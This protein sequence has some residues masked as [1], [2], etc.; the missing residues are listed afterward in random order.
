[1]SGYPQM[2]AVRFGG[3]SEVRAIGALAPAIQFKLVILQRETQALGH[4]ILLLFDGFVFKLENFSAAKANQVIVV[5]AGILELVNGSA[6]KKPALHG[7]PRLYQAADGA[8]NGSQP[9]PGGLLFHDAEEFFGGKM[10]ARLHKFRNDHLTLARHLQLVFRKVSLIRLEESVEIVG[11]R[12]WLAFAFGAHGGGIPE[13]GSFWYAAEMQRFFPDFGT[14]YRFP[15]FEEAVLKYWKDQKIFERLLSTKDKRKWYGFYDGPPFATGL[16]HYGHLIG[17]TLKD[18][19]P[20]YWSMRG[21]HVERRFGWDCHG[22]P[23]EFEMEKT[24][25]LSG[26]L[27]IR[28]YGVDKF[29]EACRGIVLRYTADWRKT[30]ERMGRWADMDNDYKTMNPEFMESV[31]WVFKELW[32]KGLIYQGKKVVPYSW[33]LTAPLSNFEASQ[34]YKSVQDPAVTVLFPLDDAPDEAILAWTTTPWTLPANLGLAVN[35]DFTYVKYPLLNPTSSGVKFAWVLRERAPAYAKELNLEKEEDEKRG[36]DLVGKTYRP[37][38]P[39]YGSHKKQGAFRVIWGDFVSA[40]DGTGIVHMAPAFGEDDF[41]ACQREKIELVDPTN[42][43]AYYTKEANHPDALDLAGKHVKDPATDKE[44][45]KWL[46]DS[47]LL[48][49]QEVLQHNYPFCERSDTPLIYK[50][51]SSWFVAVEKVKDRMQAN[52]QTIHWV[53]GHIRDGRFGKWLENARDWC[54]SRNRFWGTPIP[55][56]ICESCGHKHV[57][58]SR[59]ELDQLAGK[60]MPDLHSHFVDEIAA[61]CPKCGKAAALKRTP[62]VLDCWFESGSMPYAQIHY[63]FEGK[64]AFDQQFPANFIAEGLDQ[65]RGWFY[66][67]TVLSTALFDKPA[68]KN[69]VVNGLVLAEDGKKMS[70]RLKNYPDPSLIMEKYGA[71]A[72][73]L[74]LMQ[75]PAVHGEELRFSEKYLVENMRAVLLPLWNSYQFFASYANIDGFNPS[76]WKNAPPVNQRPRIDQWILA[77]LQETESKMHKEMESYEL[78]NVFPLLAKFLDN[79]TNWYIRLNRSRYWENKGSEFSADKLSAYST[80]FEVLDRF[81]LL[82]APNLPFFSE[83]L[84]SALHYG[85]NPEKLCEHSGL[86]SVH[87][88]LYALPKALAADDTALIAEMALAQRAI[89]LGRSLR[90][91]ARI[92]LRQPLQRMSLAGLL[93]SDQKLLKAQENMV[94]SE[95]NLKELHFLQDGSGLVVESVKPNLKKLGAKLGRKMQSVQ[96]ELKSWGAKEITAFEQA[97]HATVAGE[98]IEKDDLFVERKAAEGKTAGALEGMVAELDTALTPALKKEGLKRELVNRIQ[99]RRKEMKFNLSDRIRVTYSAGG[100]CEEILRE[101]SAHPSFLSTETLAL[102]FSNG[103]SGLGEKEAFEGHGDAWLAF[104]L[105]TA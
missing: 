16:P 14:D 75:S 92:G 7:E 5:M 21:Y 102:G 19:V 96:Q 48:L 34:N 79:L 97:G 49:K 2:L 66:T 85:V 64:A 13:I 68:F 41:Y 8:V 76:L 105:E 88:R 10:A 94:L 95:L 25:N 24:L 71:D 22:L 82:L 53:P 93:P 18:I 43:E 54:I 77:L 99:Q 32:N 37:L 72:L 70:K 1:L 98:K 11:G 4:L 28:A 81:G 26:S 69:C 73:R 58:G 42:Q 65:T 30:V 78:A 84:H 60:P 27:A 56:W 23:V 61:D 45:V 83:Y 51:I 20:R 17:G 15:A 52:N 44:I 57:V 38:F 3:R 40:T 39:Y 35:K 67:L 101:E 33:R 59:A 89:L 62:E 100:L 74:Y 103:A 91:E 31:W 104:G 29:N 86:P 46:K 80:L 12:D 87:E 63:P 47:G 9:H 50:A 6:I 55:V 36:V 90:A